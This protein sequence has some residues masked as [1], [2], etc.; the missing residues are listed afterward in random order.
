MA[1]PLRF[2]LKFVIGFALLTGAFEASRGS[3]VEKFLVED[4]ILVPA[5]YLINAATPGEHVV[6][7]G[8]TI[9]SA[10]S[11]LRVT[12]GCEGIE[13]FIL[14]AAAIMS[15]PAGLKRRAQGLLM[16]AALAYVLSVSRLML[17]HYILRYS[18]T[19]WEAL[20]G[21]V[22]PLGPIILMALYFM[23][24]TA[25]ALPAQPRPEPHAA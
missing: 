19:A 5:T 6:L 3:S 11:N 16:G 24:W 4:I 20:H 1:M 13:M 23:W 21:L 2:G 14:L 12:R 8:R 7:V 17:L 25:A 9:S 15:F 22:L 10:G 18:P